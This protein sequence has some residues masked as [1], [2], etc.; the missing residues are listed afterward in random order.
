MSPLQKILEAPSLSWAVWILNLLV[1]A[2]LMFWY[3]WRGEAGLQLEKFTQQQQ[4]VIELLQVEKRGQRLPALLVDSEARTNEHGRMVE[5]LE[6][7]SR[8]LGKMSSRLDEI[9]L[10][11]R[12]VGGTR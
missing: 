11:H 6:K 2:A 10:N 5:V 7:M 12:I 9:E 8:Q 1:C 4:Q 3:D